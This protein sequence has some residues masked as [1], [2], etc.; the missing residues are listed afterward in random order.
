MKYLIFALFIFLS[1]TIQAQNVWYVDRDSPVADNPS[2]SNGMSWETAWA[3]LDSSVW[4]GTGGVNWLV[5]SPG[6]TI[7]VSGGT[8]STNYIPYS[9][10]AN[11]WSGWRRDPPYNEPITFASQVVITKAWHE[12]HNGEVWFTTANDSQYSVFIGAGIDRVKLIHLNFI[13]RRTNSMNAGI[14]SN[15]MT[16]YGKDNTVDSC[17]LYSRG[18]VAGVGATAENFHFTNNVFEYEWNNLPNSTDPIGIG[19]GV[20]GHLIDRNVFILRNGYTAL[21]GDGT[22]MTTTS[23]SMTVTGLDMPIDGYI[24]VQVVAGAYFMDVTSNSEDTFYG[25]GGWYNSE[26]IP[27]GPPSNGTAWQI[28]GSHRDGFQMSGDS[29]DGYLTTVISNNFLI[30]TREEGNGWNA[31]MYFVGNANIRHLIFNNVIVNRKNNTTL[32]GGFSFNGYW[33]TA[34]IQTAVILN[35]TVITKGAP[36]GGGCIVANIDSVIAMNNL[37]VVDT[38]VHSDGLGYIIA[39]PDYDLLSHNRYGAYNYSAESP[40]FFVQNN[41]RTWTY[42]TET[43]GREVGGNVMDSRA[44][45]FDNKYDSTTVTAYYTTTGRDSGIDLSTDAGVYLANLVSEYPALNYDILGNPRGTNGSWDI[46][47]LEYQGEAEPTPSARGWAKGSN[48]KVWRDS[49]G[50]KMKVQQ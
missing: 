33:S 45:T 23:T 31:M 12:G 18:L 35:N 49:T 42:L 22:G 10:V 25:T 41:Y 16:M 26:G 36:R 19:T 43:L 13:D 27:G 8:D 7:Y 11:D 30:D 48:D 4:L 37:F 15:F 2:A 50:K 28:S 46:G 40:M 3:S 1:V 14:V 29:T 39:T 5:I 38:T 6:D 32:Q 21:G 47:A 44:I 20:G 17:Y 9:A 24:G 34:S